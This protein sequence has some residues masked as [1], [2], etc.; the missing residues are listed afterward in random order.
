MGDTFRGAAIPL[1]EQRTDRM[2]LIISLGIVFA[3]AVGGFTMAANS[4]GDQN[5]SPIDDPQRIVLDSFDLAETAQPQT[6]RELSFVME[7]ESGCWGPMSTEQGWIEFYDEYIPGELPLCLN[8]ETLRGW[9]VDVYVYGG[10]NPWELGGYIDV[11]QKGYNQGRIKVLWTHMGDGPCCAYDY[12]RATFYVNEPVCLES[13]QYPD[14]SPW[15]IH[16]PDGQETIPGKSVCLQIMTYWT[17]CVPHEVP[18]QDFTIIHSHS[19][20]LSQSVSSSLCK[21]IHRS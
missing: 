20:K 19:Y 9:Y 13:S 1:T 12:W 11:W 8:N 16:Y 3:L 14:V 6:L 17:G 10:Y 15:A 7:S 2:I 5:K 4:L 21:M 18:S